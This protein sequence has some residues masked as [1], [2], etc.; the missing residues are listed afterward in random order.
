MRRV[1][2]RVSLVIVMLGVATASGYQVFLSEQNI[3]QEREAERT[4]MALGWELTVSLADLRA[5][6]QAYVAAGQDN[7]YWMTRVAAQLESVRAD[8]TSLSLASTAPGTVS[9]LDDARTSIDNLAR[10]DARARDH[11]AAGQDLLASDLIF[12]DGLE[13]ARNAAS[14]V[15][16]ARMTERASHDASTEV[17][18]KSQGIA[19]A[20]AMGTGVFVALLLLPVAPL[21]TIGNT[22]RNTDDAAT[23]KG[24]SE[25]TTLPAWEVD[26]E[27]DRLAIVGEPDLQRKEPASSQS[28]NIRLAAN[29]CTDIGR[30]STTSELPALLARAAQI[31]NASGI[32][33]W[34][35]DGSGSAL[36]PAIGHGY[37]TSTL[38]RHGTIPCDGDNAT[39]AAFRE[40]KMHVVPGS[41]SSTGAIV[42]PLM[43]ATTC[44]GVV[45]MELNNGWESSQEVQS[46]AAII[47]AQLAT[48]VAADAAV[49]D[50]TGTETAQIIHS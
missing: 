7:S 18:R 10:M 13:L 21:T 31:L 40:N 1:W 36:R 2:L 33:I 19:L 44:N 34:V 22:E 17:H 39:A 30:M 37:S 28:P 12:T 14:H 43:S 47:T 27:S 42:A 15:Q 48:L 6:Q 32:I 11:S 38:A 24:G 49:D 4:F 16:L 46:T 41:I 9:A 20:T 23:E 25:L 3:G 8:L 26:L 50:S 35:L 5:S 29:L 45:S